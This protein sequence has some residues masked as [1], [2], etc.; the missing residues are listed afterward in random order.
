[1]QEVVGYLRFRMA[2]HH[3]VPKSTYYLI[4]TALMAGTGLTVAAAFIDMGVF[5]NVVAL[6]IAVTQSCSPFNAAIAAICEID[7]GLE[8]LCD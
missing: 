7:V 8:V 2:E 3:I 4:F 5:N 1:M 6:T